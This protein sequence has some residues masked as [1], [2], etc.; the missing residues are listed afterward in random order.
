MTH[1]P[2][3]DA[4]K[5]TPFFCRRFL[6]WVS[7]SSWAGFVWY[8]IPTPIR[9]LFYSKPESAVHVTEMIIYDLLFSTWLWLQYRYNNSDR[10]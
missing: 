2:E 10:L 8:Q 7:C 5:S 9:T 4:T 1:A 6:V 3:T